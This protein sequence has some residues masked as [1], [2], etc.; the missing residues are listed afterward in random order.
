MRTLLQITA[1][2]N[3]GSVGR[4]AEEIGEL[5]IANGWQSYI[6]YG[7]KARTSKSELIR[8]GAE[9]DVKLHGIKTRLF[10]KHGFGSQKATRRLIER[11]EEIRPDI[12]HLHCIHGYYINMEILF[13]Y[14]AKVEIPVVWTMHDC[15]AMTGH[16]VHFENIGCDKWKN[17]CY[18]CPNKTGYPGSMLLD[19][20]RSNYNQKKRLFSSVDKLTIVSVCD[21]LARLLSKSF[22]KEKDIR[23]IY[24]GINTDV[25]SPK[26]P[27]EEMKNRLG[28][29]D[30]F[31]ILAVSNGWNQ[32]KGLDD[33]IEFGRNLEPNT[34]LVIVGLSSRQNK[35]LPKQITAVERTESVKQLAE[36]YSLADVLINPTYQ[37]TLPTVNIEAIA[38]GTP[39]VTYRTG[40]SADIIDEKSGYVVDMGDMEGLK[41]AI[42]EVRK[43]GKEAYSNHCRKRALGM[44]RKEERF[45][46]YLSLYNDLSFSNQ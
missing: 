23:V 33:L 32:T 18:S 22:L 46:E 17:G 11:L 34:K 5:V 20:S 45:A 1:M 42:S 30:E 44:F 43:K 2:V 21:W 25:F 29:K 28:I 26:K 19:N 24:N 6:A 36:L 31:V 40:G 4:I 3:S 35:D 7:R 9:R 12:V 37:D 27:S 16:C 38:C 14:L 15:W 8:I 13:D 10:D 39:V 41:E